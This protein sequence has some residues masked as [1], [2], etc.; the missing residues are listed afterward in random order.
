MVESKQTMKGKK[1]CQDIS[2]GRMQLR[3]LYIHVELNVKGTGLLVL[4]LLKQW[5]LNRVVHTIENDKTGIPL[6]LAAMKYHL[7]K[8]DT[9]KSVEGTSMF[10]NER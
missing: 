4:A 6:I 5:S 1:T 8:L 10:G 9:Q 3:Q 2:R 7:L